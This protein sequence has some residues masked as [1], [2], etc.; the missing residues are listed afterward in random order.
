[1]LKCYTLIVVRCDVR[2]LKENLYCYEIYNVN[3]VGAPFH[4]SLPANPAMNSHRYLVEKLFVSTYLTEYKSGRIFDLSGKVSNLRKRKLKRNSQKRSTSK[5]P[6][7][8][9]LLRIISPSLWN[10]LTT[11]EGALSRMAYST[12]HP[13]KVSFFGLQIL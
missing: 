4:M 3:L 7:Y 12:N 10:Y 2:A 11:V 6:F 13:L 5:V 8:I 9:F 1:S